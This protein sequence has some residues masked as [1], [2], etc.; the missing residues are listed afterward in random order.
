MFIS[1]LNEKYNIKLLDKNNKELLNNSIIGNGMKLQHNNGVDTK[2][3]VLIVM[4]DTTGDGTIN[5]ADVVKIADHSLTGN[6]LK[7]QYDLFSA[8]VT[9]DGIINIADVVKIADY[10]LDNSVNL[11]R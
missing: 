11:W 6:V 3:Y 2:E 10:T 7:E 9:N 1:N 5:I 8:D 4:G